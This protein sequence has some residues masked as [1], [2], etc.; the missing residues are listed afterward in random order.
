[1]EHETEEGAQKEQAQ[2][3]LQGRSPSD[4]KWGVEGTRTT[5][6]VQRCSSY[7]CAMLTFEEA[8]EAFSRLLPLGMS[9]RQALNLMKP[10]GKA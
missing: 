5:P 7:F 3:C 6:G 10:V 2:T 9:A 8:A 4:K 1:M